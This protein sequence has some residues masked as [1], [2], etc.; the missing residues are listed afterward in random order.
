MQSSLLTHYE[1]LK[2][3]TVVDV[4]FGSLPHESPWDMCRLSFFFLFPNTTD[5]CRFQ[6]LQAHLLTAVGEGAD[7]V[8]EDASTFAGTDP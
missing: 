2:S 5:V 4:R 6:Q 3:S 8:V 7:T 1:S